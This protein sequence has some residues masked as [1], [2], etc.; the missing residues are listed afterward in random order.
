MTELAKYIL[1]SEARDDIVE[2]IDKKAFE[3]FRS[4]NDEEKIVA[5]NIVSSLQL[6]F[7]ELNIIAMEAQKPD[8]DEGIEE[9]IKR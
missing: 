2:R 4:G 8:P 5:A 3:K 1:N 6:F 7:T 9:D